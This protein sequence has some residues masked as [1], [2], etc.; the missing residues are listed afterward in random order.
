MSTRHASGPQSMAWMK[1]SS[2]ILDKSK[3]N[4]TLLTRK[5]KRTSLSEGALEYDSF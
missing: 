3:K 4:I 1:L 5:W 2:P